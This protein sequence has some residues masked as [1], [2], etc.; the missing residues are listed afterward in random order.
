MM[1]PLLLEVCEGSF[2]KMTFYTSF[3]MKFQYTI[4]GFVLFYQS[5]EMPLLLGCEPEEGFLDLS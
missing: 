2:S 5:P 4:D 3:L 1:L